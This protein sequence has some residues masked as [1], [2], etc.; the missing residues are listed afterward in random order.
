MKVFASR[1]RKPPDRVERGPSKARQVL[2]GH[3]R[4][5]TA[6][7]AHRIDETQFTPS[8]AAL[9]RIDTTRFDAV[10]PLRTEHYAAIPSHAPNCILPDAGVVA[11]CNDKLALRNRLAALGFA[12][13]LP[14]EVMGPRDYPCLLKPR[15][16]EF[17]AGIRVLNCPEPVPEGYFLE[18]LVPG[19]REYALHLLVSKGLVVYHQAIRYEMDGEGLIRSE[20]CVPK[21]L[22]LADAKPFLAWAAGLVKTIGYEGVCC[23]NFKVFEGQPMLFEINPRFG[24]SLIYDVTRFVR[25]YC[26][27]VDARRALMT[28]AA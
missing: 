25:A 14:R 19:A 9:D 21:A 1:P 3:H 10:I 13:V 18:R 8:F 12:S 17:G 20:T 26:E 27:E 11:L 22:H 2:F 23:F 4:R 7:I 6:Q 16:G 28:P 5:L 15:H 24:G